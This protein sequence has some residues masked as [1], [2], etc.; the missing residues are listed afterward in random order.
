MFSFWK[1]A[2]P[3]ATTKKKLLVNDSVLTD[4]FLRLAEKTDPQD[5]RFRF[6]LALILMR[7]RILR[8]ESTEPLPA[9]RQPPPP[10]NAS[11]PPPP[12]EVWLMTLRGSEKEDRAPQPVKVVN[13][14]LNPEQ[15]SDV[16]NQLS[17][18]LAEEI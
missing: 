11:P 4:L 2:V 6:V 14:R 8:Y 5:L 16:S 12:A 7:K 1:T 3:S 9:S 10:E 15:I 18:I 13:P 17:Q